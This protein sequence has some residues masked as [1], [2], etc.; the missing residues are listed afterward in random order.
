MLAATLF[1]FCLIGGGT[2]SGE[3]VPIEGAIP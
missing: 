1:L 3:Q 2:T